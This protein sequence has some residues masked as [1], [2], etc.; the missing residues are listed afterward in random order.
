[1]QAEH[2][3]DSQKHFDFDFIKYG[4][5]TMSQLYLLK[6]FYALMFLF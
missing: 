6:Y 2:L 4:F 1:M 5:D 3:A